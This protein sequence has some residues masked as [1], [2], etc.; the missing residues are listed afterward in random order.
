LNNFFYTLFLPFKNI[1]SIDSAILGIF[2]ITLPIDVLF[3]ARAKD[4]ITGGQPLLAI[5]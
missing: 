3:F 1:L 4:G 5:G 2:V